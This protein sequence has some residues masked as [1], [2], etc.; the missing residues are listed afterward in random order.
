MGAVIVEDIKNNPNVTAI[1]WA[2]LPGQESGNAITDILY[3]ARNPSAKSVFTWGKKREDWGTDIIYTPT[4]TPNQ[5]DFDEGVFID[6]RH[7]D[8]QAIEPSYEFGFGLSYTNFT[9]SNLQIVKNN[10]G[11]YEPTTGKTKAAP[12]L[13]TIDTN[14]DSAEYPPGFRAIYKYVYPYLDGPVLRNQSESW[15]EKAADGSPQPRVGAGGSAGGNRQ[16]WDV[17]YT[18]SATVKNTGGVK[19]VEI[20]QLYL[21]LGGPTDPKVVLR[22]FDDLILDAGEEGI[23]TYGLTRRDVS[24]WDTV[25]QNWV[26]SPF[27]KTVYVGRSSRDLVLSGKLA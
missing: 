22:A 11:P 15:P 24:N 14:E 16:L 23:F 2:G 25:S 5:L 4:E 20:P 7:F 3:G 27:E 19:G 6:Y 13:G 12:I 9:Y 26:V 10:P 8:K 1:L 18:V 21:S 17:V